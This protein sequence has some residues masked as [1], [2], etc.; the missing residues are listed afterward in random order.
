MK[1]AC[2][3]WAAAISNVIEPCAISVEFRS[4]LQDVAAEVIFTKKRVR[5]SK[6]TTKGPPQ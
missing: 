5:T 3:K 6:S 4:P 2:E 1:G